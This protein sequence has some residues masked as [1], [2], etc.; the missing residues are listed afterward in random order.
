MENENIET[1]LNNDVIFLRSSDKTQVK[2]TKEM[3]KM[4]DDVRE[5]ESVSVL[6]WVCENK[7]ISGYTNDGVN[8]KWLDPKSNIVMTPRELYKRFK[9]K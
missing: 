7:F 2:K 6:K 8:F 4:L 5:Q 9:S 3:C 1:L